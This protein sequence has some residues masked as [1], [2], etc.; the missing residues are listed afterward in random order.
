MQEDPTGQKYGRLEEEGGMGP[1]K[2][3]SQSI[4]KNNH[5]QQ[6]TLSLATHTFVFVFF[7]SFFLV[8]CSFSIKESWCS[9]K[10]GSNLFSNLSV[11]G[12]W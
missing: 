7:Q 9:L 11:T 12:N 5:L 4:F 6:N 10:S 1:D 3:D 8:L 2:V